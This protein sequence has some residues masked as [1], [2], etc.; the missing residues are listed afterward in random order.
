MYSLALITDKHRENDIG[1]VFISFL[2]AELNN[3]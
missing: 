3:P 2:E 1:D